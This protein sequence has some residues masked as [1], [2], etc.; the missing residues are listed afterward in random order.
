MTLKI[1]T[2]EIRYE[3]DVV[4]TR[5]RTRQIA[6][7]LG[8]KVTEQTRMATAVSE[9]A[10]NAFQYA[11]GG[12]VEFGVAG[13]IPQESGTSEVTIEAREVG[14]VGYVGKGRLTPPNAPIAHSLHHPLAPSCPLP[15]QRFVI[16][17]SDKGPG[18][19][20]LNHILEGQYTSRTGMGI[21]ILG[22]KRLMDQFQIESKPGQGT[23]V[24][25]GKH[26]PKQT[27]PLTAQRLT[28]ITDELIQRSPQNPFE[29]IQQQNQE[30]L[31]ALEELRQRE[32]SLTHLNR[33]LEDTNR[34]VV[35]LYAELDE[36]ADSLKRANELK[37]RF[38]SNMSH[39][40]RTPL[41]SIMSL[42]RLL[43][44]RIDGDLTP[45][46]ETQVKFIRQSAEG[47]SELVNDLLDLAKVEAG[48]IVVHANS[49]EVKELFATLR[50]MLRPLLAHNS[51][52]SLIFEAPQDCPTLYT[53]E[54]KVA[55]ILRNFISNSL[56]YTERGEVRVAATLAGKTI[57]FSVS[58]TGVGIAPADTERI[59]EEFVQVESAMQ[60]RFKGTGLGLPLSRKLAELL[61][62]SIWATSTLKV[63][64]TFYAS[65]P[66]HAPGSTPA[67]S[68]QFQSAP[69]QPDPVRM[70]ILVIEDNAETLFTYEKYFEG[71]IY[72]PFLA[73]TLEQ[74][75]QILASF[76][77]QAIIMDIL[78]EEQNT[79]ALLCEL[80]E[81]PAT[82]MIPI[83]VITVID[84]E[85]KAK[86]LG[87]EAFLIKPVDR[88][89]LLNKI[90]M[91][92][93]RDKPQT[94]LLID[95]DLADRYVLKQLLKNCT[96]G[97]TPPLCLI[98]ANQGR[99]GVR[100][101]QDEKPDCIILDLSMP[102]LSGTEVLSLLK[103]DPVTQPIPVLI[104]TS[105]PLEADEKRELTLRSIAVL[106]KETLSSEVAIQS[107]QEAL[108]KAGVAF[109]TQ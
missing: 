22:T 23:T 62:G 101:A 38:L 28:Q 84:N 76:T 71:T 34:G 78:L 24:L 88:L 56:K 20:H 64:S 49:F 95:N 16:T 108:V 70:P 14:R 75:K 35:A 42:S 40:F 91:L 77:P 87:A 8:F 17:I 5:Q 81:N 89:S 96:D 59:F 21:G 46:Q 15:S 82:R 3:Q 79:W 61:G 9:I 100:L 18:I 102:E 26:L 92:V 37:T 94:L 4:L 107:L 55:Q 2:L 60:Q 72:Q 103:S 57:T 25:M 10:R 1:L 106:S 47:L 54:G 45:E 33:E 30:L 11:G 73:R 13:I 7:L 98:E 32:E 39:E 41:N 90:N 29:E 27:S 80:K 93:K 6:E 66:I 44:E 52:I 36:K 99:D 83:V 48:K 69:P 50:G 97:L 51:S 43:L 58:D 12:R 31:Q 86:A 85:A 74:A 53:D 67:S 68:E 65:I 104:H 109:G 105:Q 63:G 19:P